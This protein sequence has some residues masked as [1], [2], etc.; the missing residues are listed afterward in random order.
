VIRVLRVPQGTQALRVFRVRQVFLVF[1]VRPR[2]QVPQELR[3]FK[4]MQA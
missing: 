2:I 4:V 1:Q 3:V